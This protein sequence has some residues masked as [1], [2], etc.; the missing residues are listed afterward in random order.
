VSQIRDF[1]EILGVSRSA[2]DAEI[3]TAYRKLA[4]QYHPDANPGDDDASEH[5]KEI[6]V[7]YEA[8]S[9]PEKRRRYDMFG[10]EGIAPGAGAGGGDAFGFGLNDLFDAFF[11]GRDPFGNERGAGAGPRRGADA[12]TL[13]DLTLEEVVFGGTKQF[14]VTM[15]VAC[16]ICEGSGCAPGTH[17]QTCESCG[18]SGEVRSVRRSILGQLVTSGPC[19][20]CAA[21][22]QVIPSPCHTC[23]GDGRVRSERKLEVEIPPGIDTGQRLRLSSRGP[24][25]PRGGPAGDLYVTVR[26]A[27]HP[28]LERAGDDLH[29]VQ[30]IAMTQAALGTTLTVPT[31]D[32]DQEIDVPS[33][34]QP[35]RVFT[36]HGLGVPSLRS[37]RRG[38]LDVHVAVD[39]PTK[40]SAEEAELLTQFAQLRGEEVHEHRDGLF[41]RIRSAFQ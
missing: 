15:P 13:L 34:T 10:P 7:A 16:D 6:S 12:E 41:S 26:V 37:G 31:L 21:T 35:G 25:G 28:G 9:D 23:H 2:N 27:E 30:T 38:N 14:D 8:L 1:Y 29:S 32:G 36:L 24:A 40:L 5:F 19:P 11:G 39:V 4:R 3:K 33:G 20:Q 17:A 22:G 18:G